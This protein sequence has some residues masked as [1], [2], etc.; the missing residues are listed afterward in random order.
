MSIASTSAGSYN[1]LLAGRWWHSRLVLAC[2]FHLIF[3]ADMSLA[4]SQL[5]DAWPSYYYNK[6]SHS[7]IL[8]TCLNKKPRRAKYAEFEKYTL[9]SDQMWAP[10]ER[11]LE[12]KP[13]DR[14]TIYEVLAELRKI[15]CQSAEMVG[16]MLTIQLIGLFNDGV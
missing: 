5:I 8:D 15:T 9:Q 11:C 1:F 14:P 7:V 2:I 12:V 16:S 6:Q 4:H 10:L 3:G 13:E